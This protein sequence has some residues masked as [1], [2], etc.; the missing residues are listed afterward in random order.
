[1]RGSHSRTLLRNEHAHGVPFRQMVLRQGA[2]L[3]EPC[4]RRLRHR[5]GLSPGL[6]RTRCL[7]D[8][9]RGARSACGSGPLEI[10]SLS[11]GFEREEA[12]RMWKFSV[13]FNDSHFP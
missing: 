1:M 5:W 9:E 11:D 12:D 2:C 6:S 7:Q 10:G 13:V 3:R 8:R 4:E